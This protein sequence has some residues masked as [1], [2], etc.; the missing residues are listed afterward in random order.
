MAQVISKNAQKKGAQK[1]LCRC[2]GEIKVYMDGSRGKK[3]MKA[4]CQ[5]CGRTARKPKDLF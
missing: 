1:L 5:S 4:Q 2:G 3:R